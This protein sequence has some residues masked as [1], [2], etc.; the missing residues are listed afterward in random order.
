MIFCHK[1]AVNKNY[2]E[3]LLVAGM[4]CCCGASDATAHRLVGELMTQCCE[5]Q[6]VPRLAEKG[7]KITLVLD[8]VTPVC[9]IKGNASDLSQSQPQSTSASRRWSFSRKLADERWDAWCR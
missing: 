6:V 5:K 1:G 2:R 3:M 9:K 7:A 8:L 4:V